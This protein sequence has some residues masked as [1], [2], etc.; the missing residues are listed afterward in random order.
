M[1][2]LQSFT[3]AALTAYVQDVELPR[4][5]KGGTE[6]LEDI[7]RYGAFVGAAIHHYSSLDR[8][9]DTARDHIRS[10]EQSGNSVENG[11]LILASSLN[12]A[13]GRFKRSW[14]APVGGLWGC[15]LLADVFL[16][17]FRNFLA[18]IPAIACCEA[19]RQYGA[20][21]TAIR[22]VNDVLLHGKKQAGFLIEGFR[23]PVHGEQ[24][25]LLGFGLNINNTTFPPE[26]RDS[27]VSL[28]QILGAP[29]DS[30][31]FALSFCAK[32]RYY[33]GLLLHEE[34]RWLAAGGRGEYQ[35]EHPILRRW[36]ELS[37][38]LGQRVQFGYD[39]MERP[40]YQALVED[41]ASNG[42]LIL[43]HDDGTHS[44]EQSGEIRYC[45][46]SKNAQETIS[47]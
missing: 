22:W 10:C 36:K 8:A 16:P 29:V 24:Y 46:V 37:D 5:R 41:I 38:T 25:H 35:G 1:D 26:L 18:L 3:P 7:F 12:V 14:H 43:R 20:S 28:A 15:L 13:K 31:S 27:A 11:S 4:R 17:A 33:I 6:N 30:S 19:V 45:A 21:S 32:L 34:A 47:R 23:S 9:M 42:A 2:S 44:T 40:Q 39:V